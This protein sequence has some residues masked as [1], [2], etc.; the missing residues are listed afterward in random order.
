LK[1]RFQEIALGPITQSAAQ[2]IV[3]QMLGSPSSAGDDLVE[4]L[5]SRSGGNPLHL[6]EL[7]RSLVAGNLLSLASADAERWNY[8][9]DEVGRSHVSVQT[10]DMLINR[11][12]A[13]L[14]AP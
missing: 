12:Q 5:H 4:F 9:M 10:V 8:D 14:D 6:I 11:L 2:L 1:R 13:R 7:S 3:G